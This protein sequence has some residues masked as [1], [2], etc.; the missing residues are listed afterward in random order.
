MPLELRDDVRTDVDA[1]EIGTDVESGI[2]SAW[3]EV[4]PL[5]LPDNVGTDVESERVGRT[6]L[7][8]VATDEEVVAFV[9]DVGF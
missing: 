1:V 3:V 5:E 2:A 8:K 7:D 4:V 9:V 6:L